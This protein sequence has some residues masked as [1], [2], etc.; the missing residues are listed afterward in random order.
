MLSLVLASFATQVWQLI[1]TQG[2]LFGAGWATAYTAFFI[3][4]NEWWVKRRGVV[5][6]IV[7]GASGVSGLALP[8]VLEAGLE[9]YGARTTLRGYAVAVFVLVGPAMLLIKPRLPLSAHMGGGGQSGPN[10]KARPRN[11]RF[12]RHPRFYVFAVAVFLQGIG[13]YLPNIFLPSFAQEVGLSHAQAAALLALLSLAQVGGQIGL[14][15]LSD[16]IDVHIPLALSALVPAMSVLLLWGFAKSFAPLVV[17]ALAYSFFGASNSVFWSRMCTLVADAG[18]DGGGGDAATAMMLYGFFSVER[19][20]GGA[21]SGPVSTA[22]LRGG[23]DVTGYGIGKYGRL[24][25]F[26]GGTMVLSSLC[27]LGWFVRN[28]VAYTGE[29]SLVREETAEESGDSNQHDDAQ[30]LDRLVV[31]GV[32]KGDP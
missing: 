28:K 27:G 3:M 21:L 9:R 18:D 24:I 26:V 23:V 2:L 32:L 14:G 4:A 5:F 11:L 10:G 16:L 15:H 29:R 25:V 1:L 31:D 8:F 19:G 6:G 22:L 7:F 12:L 17:F 20:I 30:E 13:F